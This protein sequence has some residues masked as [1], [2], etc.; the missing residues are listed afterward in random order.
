LTGPNLVTSDVLII[1]AGP[2][3]LT[4]AAT[5]APCLRGQVLVL[6]RE[7]TPGGI[8]RH[9]DHMGY[10]LRDMHTFI[11]GPAY[12]RRLIDNASRAGAGVRTSAT[13]TGWC[14]PRTVEVTSPEGR[15]RISGRAIIL[16]TG[17]RE[18]PRAARLI[19]GDRPAGVYT[20]GQ[21]QNLVHIHHRS[22]GTSAVIVGAEL[23]SWSAA[24]T[25]RQA[26]CRPVLMTSVH[27]RPE[28]PAALSALGRIA[29]RLP[30]RTRTRVALIIGKRRVHAVELEDLDTRRRA[31]VTCDTV[32]VTGDWIP[33]NELARLAGLE[34]D[35]H[36]LGPIVD[37]SQATSTPGIYAIGNLTH[38][39][40]TADCAALD[41]RAIAQTVIEY[42]DGDAP[43][44]AATTRVLPGESLAWVSPGILKR[45]IAPP[46]DRF[47][48]WPREQIPYPTITV[49]QNGHTIACRTLPWPASPGRIL[50]IPSSLLLAAHVSDDPITVDIH[51]TRHRRAIL[52]KRTRVA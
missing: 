30:V 6:E 15:E 50:R 17:A 46:R 28:S 29:F 34:L 37:T 45:G 14:A 43:A 35:P 41:G 24:M 4:A 27:S 47:L 1:G 26:G 2:S 18:R 25:L 44:P 13:V 3:G 5:I 48:A 11:T 31:T 40:D 39:V 52:R 23:V 7:M 42:L 33:D 20:T 51:P 22:P 38:P 16:A 10:G 32:I 49:A 8:P 12:A 9:S 36:T 21:L 19:A